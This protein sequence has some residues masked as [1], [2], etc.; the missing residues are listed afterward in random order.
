MQLPRAIRRMRSFRDVIWSH[1]RCSTTS[2]LRWVGLG[3]RSYTNITLPVARR[4][5]AA[6]FSKFT[7]RL[8]L[9]VKQLPDLSSPHPA[10]NHQEYS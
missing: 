2:F 4:W 3:S 9:I 7:R 5:G 6:K 10:A 8:R 1:Y